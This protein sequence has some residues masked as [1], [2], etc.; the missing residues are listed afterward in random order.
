MNQRISVDE[1]FMQMAEV[2][3][4]RGT[5]IRRQVGCVLVN[6]RKQVLSTG[7]N[8]TARGTL[9]CI[10]SPC[11]G[12]KFSEGQGLDVCEAI[13]AESNAI[14]QCHN[15]EEIE[16]CYSTTEPCVHCTKLLL[17]TGCRA[18]VFRNSYASG[19][20]DL[21]VRAKSSGTWRYLVA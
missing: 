5:C 19:G 15:V 7:Y 1:W 12:H 2:T 11:Q 17:N 21:W 16:T 4:R 20:M 9:H 14:L 6:S 10:D 3:A 13:H 18:V 8:G